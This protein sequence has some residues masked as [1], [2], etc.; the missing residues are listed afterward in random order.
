MSIDNIDILKFHVFVS[1]TDGTRSWHGT[2]IQC[3]QPLPLSAWLLN[4]E[5]TTAVVQT[6]GSKHVAS[7]PVVS[8]IPVKKSK[9]RRRTI[10]EQPSL[11]TRIDIPGTVDHEQQHEEEEIISNF[12]NIDT[13]EYNTLVQK[14]FVMSEF[15]LNITESDT[16]AKLQNDIFT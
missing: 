12:S 13:A 15:L 14:P 3:T 2:S 10:T 7:S 5:N 9:C 1:S 16:L 4:D 8:P 11:H 6:A